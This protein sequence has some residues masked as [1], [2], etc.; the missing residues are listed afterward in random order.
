MQMFITLNVGNIPTNIPIRNI[1]ILTLDQQQFQ[2]ITDTMLS[3]LQNVLNSIPK[4]LSPFYG[5]GFIT[6]QRKSV[7]VVGRGG[8]GDFWPKLSSGRKTPTVG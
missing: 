2:H 1:Y 4:T 8:E 6:S 5:D 3:E 7:F